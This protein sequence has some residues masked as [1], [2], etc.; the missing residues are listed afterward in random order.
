[1]TQLKASST[2]DSQ[3]DPSETS[4]ALSRRPEFVP[5][6]AWQ[7][8]TKVVAAGK[9]T[10]VAVGHYFLGLFTAGI[11]LTYAQPTNV[12]EDELIRSIQERE[13]VIEG[14][15]SGA[16]ELDVPWEDRDNWPDRCQL[17]DEYDDEFAGYRKCLYKCRDV[18]GQLVWGRKP[19]GTPCDKWGGGD[20]WFDR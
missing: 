6:W 8:A 12:G 15:K 18:P 16:R 2:T 14:F 9:V 13:R 17:Y 4:V 19:L 11:I 10:A 7:I 1:H 5:I 20:E 3:S